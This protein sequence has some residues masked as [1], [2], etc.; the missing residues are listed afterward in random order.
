VSDRTQ[1][2][3][4][5]MAFSYDMPF[6][7]DRPRFTGGVQERTPHPSE[8]W[9]F[10]QNPGVAGMAA[11]DDRITLNPFS[12]NPPQAQRAVAENEAARVHMRT[13]PTLRPNFDITPEQQQRFGQYGSP[14]DIR[15]TIAARL[16]SGDPSAGTANPAQV[17]HRN[18]LMGAF[19]QVPF[20]GKP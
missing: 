9:Y 13:N 1:L 17:K 20:M 5:L 4:A 15:Q 16:L 19:G 12:P 14:D 18:A 11:E 7:A 10:A 8:M 2:A 3:N 6:G